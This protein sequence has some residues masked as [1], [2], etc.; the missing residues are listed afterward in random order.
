[1]TI[2]IGDKQMMEWSEYIEE[3]L[4]EPDGID[5][6]RLSFDSGNTIMPIPPIIKA[7]VFLMDKM[8]KNQGNRHGDSEWEY[9]AESLYPG[10]RP[11]GKGCM[12]LLPLQ[13]GMRF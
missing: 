8:V 5:R 10:E 7:S 4:S 11:V 2:V 12:Y 9:R 1:M 13:Q 6:I 3:L